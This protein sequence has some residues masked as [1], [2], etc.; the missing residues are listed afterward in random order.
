MTRDEGI[1]LNKKFDGTCSSKYIESFSNYIGITVEQ[2][3]E[4]VDKSVNLEL[5]KK[6]ETGKYLPKFEVGIG[7]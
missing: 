4:Q 2:F 1:L 3:W 7:L 5:F 6:I